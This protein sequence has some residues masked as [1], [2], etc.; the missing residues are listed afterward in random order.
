MRV[1]RLWD[2]Q[3][4]TAFAN[5]GCC[6]QSFF[7]TI[8]AYQQ[9]TCLNSTKETE[10]LMMLPKTCGTVPGIGNG[11]LEPSCPGKGA[12]ALERCLLQETASRA[13]LAVSAAQHS[14]AA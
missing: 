13:C 5:A 6:A 3:G 11:P 7:D 8:T 4:C 12:A 10:L 1:A 2:A 14:R 9:L